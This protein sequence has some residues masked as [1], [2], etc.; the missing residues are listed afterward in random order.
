MQKNKD[1][2]LEN[3]IINIINHHDITQQSDLQKLLKKQNYEIPQATL[4]RKLEKLNIAKI[5]G[6]YT[7]LDQQNQSKP[8]VLNIQISEFGIIILTTYPGNAGSLAYYIDQKCLN[9][10]SLPQHSPIIGTIAG[11]DT[12]MIVVRSKLDMGKALELLKLDFPSIVTLA[13]TNYFS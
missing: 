13:P 3:A 12:V 7:K 2:E 4:S 11:D 10:Y 5:S 6:K 8:S 9:M 1:R